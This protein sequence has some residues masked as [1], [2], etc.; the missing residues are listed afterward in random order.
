MS[1][2]QLP[3][4]PQGAVVT[5]VPQDVGTFRLTMVRTGK[6]AVRSDA[7][8]TFQCGTTRLRHFYYRAEIV[9]R[10]DCLDSR[11]FMVD[12][13]E[14]HAAF[15]KIAQACDP[16]P[17]CERFALIFCECVRRLVGEALVSVQVGVSGVPGAAWMT[18]SWG[19][20]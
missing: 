8:H 11:G 17:S 1:T 3:D 15:C 18:A 10:G 20:Q 9:T 5:D 14:V 6:V 19:R 12:Q 2:V 4:V 13:L 7:D 16:V